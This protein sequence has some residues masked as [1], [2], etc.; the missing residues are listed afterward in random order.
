MCVDV[1]PTRDDRRWGDTSGVAGHISILLF[2]SINLE[3]FSSV[4]RS[5]QESTAG[6]VREIMEWTVV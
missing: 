3:T 2:C 5:R 4:G 1:L 6:T